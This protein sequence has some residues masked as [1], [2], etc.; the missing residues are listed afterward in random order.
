MSPVANYDGLEHIENSYLGRV[1]FPIRPPQVALR[2][3]SNGNFKLYPMEMDHTKYMYPTLFKPVGVEK[4]PHEHPVKPNYKISGFIPL[5]LWFNTYRYV[6]LNA[7]VVVDLD[8]CQE[9]LCDHYLPEYGCYI[10]CSHR[11]MEASSSIHRRLRPGQSP[12]GYPD[13]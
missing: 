1:S 2:M 13:A 6:A 10:S 12:N 11:Q 3:H 8:I 5:Q 9:I 7:S 4:G